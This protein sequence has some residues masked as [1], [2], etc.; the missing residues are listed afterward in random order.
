MSPVA[1]QASLIALA[2]RSIF[3]LSPPVGRLSI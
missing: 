1:P 3:S 2:T